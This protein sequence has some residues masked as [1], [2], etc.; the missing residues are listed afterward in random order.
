M[1]VQFARPP[2]FF[3]EIDQAMQP[4]RNALRLALLDGYS[5]RNDRNLRPAFDFVTVIT[6]RQFELCFAGTNEVVLPK[7]KSLW[8]DRLLSGVFQMDA[9]SHRLSGPVIYSS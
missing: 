8:L 4:V 1:D 9:A 2:T 6:G 7:R 3:G 5:A